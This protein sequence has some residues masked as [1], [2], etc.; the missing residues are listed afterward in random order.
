M[1]FS[2]TFFVRL[3]K[4]R[5]RTAVLR[6]AGKAIAPIIIDRRISA[7]TAK[8]YKK[9]RE[10]GRGRK[11]RR[12]E[13]RLGG[14]ELNADRI[15]ITQRLASG[16]ISGGVELTR[17]SCSK[18]PILLRKASRLRVDYNSGFLVCRMFCLDNNIHWIEPKGHCVIKDILTFFFIWQRWRLCCALVESAGQRLAKVSDIQ[19]RC[20]VFLL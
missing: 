4:S 6:A 9:S 10:K 12:R 1:K 18:G 14:E 8:K 20:V 19:V 17:K 15:N 3:N 5:G 2:L 16:R 7:A 11:H 13:R